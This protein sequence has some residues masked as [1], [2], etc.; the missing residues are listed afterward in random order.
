MML[1]VIFST[2]VGF[3]PQPIAA[4]L[5]RRIR[6][7]AGLVCPGKPRILHVAQ[8]SFAPPKEL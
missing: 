5:A 7:G 8:R 2:P 4:I 6:E 1:N 3:G